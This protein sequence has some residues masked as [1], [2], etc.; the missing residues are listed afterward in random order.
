MIDDSCG[1]GMLL[2]IPAL[3]VRILQSHD[4]SKNSDLGQ[5]GDIVV[6]CKYAFLVFLSSGLNKSI[7]GS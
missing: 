3:P 7:F 6:S 2:L 1:R 4:E 5:S